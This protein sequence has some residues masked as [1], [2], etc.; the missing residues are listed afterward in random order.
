[1]VRSAINAD[2]SGRQNAFPEPTVVVG[3]GRVGLSVL[4]RLGEDWRLAQD[5]AFDESLRNLR[6]LHLRSGE[7]ED[8]ATAADTP[9]AKAKAPDLH[10]AWQA[11][12]DPVR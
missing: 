10:P 4:T 1:M 6:L 2:D 9:A 12:E 7:F 5:L 8:P 11:H 3:L